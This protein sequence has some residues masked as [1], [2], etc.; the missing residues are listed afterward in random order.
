MPFGKPWEG[1]RAPDL[2]YAPKGMIG[3]EERRALY[4]IGRNYYTGK[5]AIVDAGAYVGASALCLA[6]GLADNPAVRDARE[7]IHSFDYF[8]AEDDY[9]VEHICRDFRPIKRGDSYLDI[10]LIQTRAYRHLIRP[11]AGDFL[12]TR[13]DNGPIEVLFIDIAKTQELN[14]HI[15]RHYFPHL[16]PGRSLVIHQDFYHCW[17]PYIH[18]TMQA[19]APYFRILD[20]HIEYQSRLY[21]YEREI[22]P[23][24][25]QEVADYCYTASERIALLETLAAQETG[26]MRAM[27]DT[28]K[29]WQF[30]QDGDRNAILQAYSAFEKTYGRLREK[31]LWWQQAQ[32]ILEY[33]NATRRR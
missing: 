4:W 20:G 17:H 30:V 28:V 32:E 22:V 26:N 1:A 33:Y 24:V 8:S 21:L 18:V 12:N 3:P 9:V 5:G 16:I 14:S 10:F 11:I 6:S 25:L 15:I 19:L 27:I 29:L 7:R 13:W 23:A 2:I 31:H